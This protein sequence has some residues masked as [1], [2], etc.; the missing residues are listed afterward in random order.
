MHTV[1]TLDA[2]IPRL[3]P[4]N[5]PVFVQAHTG[6]CLPMAALYLLRLR[7][8]SH[9]EN[10][11]GSGK[12]L[13]AN[14]RFEGTA[15]S[16]WPY[17]LNT[18]AAVVRGAWACLTWPDGS[19]A[20]ATGWQNG[21]WRFSPCAL[22]FAPNFHHRQSAVDT[23]ERHPGVPQ[24]LAAIFDHRHPHM[25]DPTF[26]APWVTGFTTA[27]GADPFL[28]FLHNALMAKGLELPA[29]T[30]VMISGSV[31][32]GEGR[33]IAPDLVVDPWTPLDRNLL[34]NGWDDVRCVLQHR[35][36]FHPASLLSYDPAWGGDVLPVFPQPDAVVTLTADASPSAHNALAFA[37][38]WPQRLAEARD[39][40]A[41]GLCR[42]DSLDIPT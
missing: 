18:Y 15:D 11:N 42:P 1:V 41:R 37:A 26:G 40:E 32:L 34:E 35:P 27:D 4:A 36:P 25:D 2:P 19:V 17:A 6:R 22:E 13:T 3:L 24:A 31:G 30:S 23:L 10:P 29:D 33:W 12:M 5:L 9:E 38:S 14:D 16:D 8:Y 7:Q 21:L 28:A 39:L 20:V